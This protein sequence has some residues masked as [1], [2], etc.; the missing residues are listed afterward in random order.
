MS[1]DNFI[2]VGNN[3]AAGNFGSP[4]QLIILLV[5]VLLLFGGNRLRNLGGDLGS[6]IKGFKKSMGDGEKKEE[7]EELPPLAD[8]N[9]KLEK[10]INPEATSNVSKSQATAEKVAKPKATKTSKPKVVSTKEQK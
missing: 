7:D 5:I 3:L 2:A 4:M 9:M 10:I 6:A 1:A 8:E